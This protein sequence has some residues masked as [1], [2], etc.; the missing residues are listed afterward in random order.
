M[1]VGTCGGI[2]GY[3]GIT[4]LIGYAARKRK[5]KANQP[6]TPMDNNGL[7]LTVNRCAK[8]H[9]WRVSASSPTSYSSAEREDLV[10]LQSPIRRNVVTPSP[11]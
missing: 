3:L 9:H 8:C 5:G 7:I 2:C 6:I 1:D 4:V 11:V 10:S